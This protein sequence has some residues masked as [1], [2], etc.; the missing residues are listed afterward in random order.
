MITLGLDIGTTTISAVAFDTS[1][2]SVL[3]S[4]NVP[5]DADATTPA[6]REAGWAEMDLQRVFNHALH[7]L[8]R[9]ISPVWTRTD[10][11]HAI[12]MT[13][14]MHGVAFLDEQFAPARPAITWQDQ[15]GSE[16]LPAFIARA[17]G[18]GAFEHHGAMPAAG[19]GGVTLFWLREHGAMPEA[20]CCSIPDAIG[21]MMC[22][23]APKI[24]ATH[25]A[26]WGV[27]DLERDEWNKAMLTQLGLPIELP[28]IVSAGTPIGNLSSANAHALGLSEGFPVT[29]AIGDHQ[30]S[31]VGSGCTRAGMAHVNIGTGGQVSLIS[32]RFT[33]MNA[34]AGIETR[35]FFR[36]L[37]VLT[38]ASLCGGSAFALLRRFYED[39]AEM[40]GLTI[41]DETAIYE[42]MVS[43]AGAVEAGADGLIADTRFDGARHNPSQLA[44]LN[45][46]SRGNFTPAHLNRAVLEGIANE[47]AQFYEAILAQH[48]AANTLAGSGNA[49]RRNELLQ[50]IVSRR[51]GLPLGM[52]AWQEEAAVGAAMLAAGQSTISNVSNSPM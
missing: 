18:A 32:D 47:L 48:G 33:P 31:L 35:P 14:Q 22:H 28:Q 27:F 24:H 39:A 19:Y 17:G 49:L 45:G 36:D 44:S 9:V 38:G 2:Q 15:R 13:G 46:L 10:E 50:S 6:Q 1:S 23:A 52:P 40:M 12:G 3:A 51:F 43:S 7:A 25:A 8:Q 4:A 42:A 5:T 20:F 11:I 37:Y 16:V 41:P 26:G 29:V 30:A 34:Q 21:A